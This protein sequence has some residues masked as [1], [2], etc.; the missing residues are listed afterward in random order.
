MAVSTLL[1][2]NSGSSSLKFGLYERGAGGLVAL[3]V[4]EADALGQAG[5]AFKAR[6]GRGREL[7]NETLALADA[8]Q[9]IGR[10]ARCLADAGHAVPGAVG[11]RLVH[12]GPDLQKHCRIDADVMRA[13]E[14]AT[15]FAPLH[16]PPALE[17][18]RFTQ[19]QFPGVAQ[20]ACFDTV[21]HAGLPDVARVL[22]L[23][24]AL[25]HDGVRRY[26]FHG[27]SCESIVRRLGEALPR[28][29]VIAH[30]G[31]GAS[32]TAVADG[33]SV[34]TS[35]GM[36]PSGGVMMG[37]RCGDLDPGVLLYLMR[38][39]GFDADRLQA[40]VNREA[41]LLG[42][43]GVSADLRHLHARAATDARADLAIRMFCYS[44]RKQIGAMVAGLGGIELLV[45]TG[46]IGQHDA[47]VR[48]AI[49]EGL[50]VMGI[51]LDARANLHG[52]TEIG[53]PGGRCEVRTMAA[54]E[55][56]QVALHSA[57]LLAAPH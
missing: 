52:A 39:K 45:F 36:T 20:V 15:P 53:A 24:H 19:Q 11:H 42:V 27:L 55:D 4:G 18:V 12:G 40:L 26:G 1:A 32:V 41:G 21:F 30:L 6:D 35:M 16:M 3:L 48:S 51:A 7:A 54:D 10:L 14:A 31:N 57:A 5:S 56:E 37:T 38:E 23:P 9:A 13:L 50:G 34:D 8:R 43:S 29:L 2:L 22:P 47:A 46:G 25:Q 44:V 49:C 28:R 33:R 17:V